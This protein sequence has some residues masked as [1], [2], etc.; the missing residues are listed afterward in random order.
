M[1]SYKTVDEYIINAKNGKEILIVLRGLI[2]TTELEETVKWGAPVYTINGKNVVGIASFKSYVGL[3]FF[4]G[5]LIK[6]TANVLIN[7]QKDIT[8]ALRQWRFT[9]IEEIN[10]KLILKYLDEAIQNQKQ[11]KEV[12]PNRNKPLVIPNELREAFNSDLKLEADFNLFTKGKQREFADY[13]SAAKRV[14]TRKIR[15]QKIIPLIQQNI[16]LNDKYRK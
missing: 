2:N 15:I 16:G 10:D 14:E 13:I 6:D 4:H 12:K 5:A 11:N 1:K 3:W 8:K 7:A 9:S